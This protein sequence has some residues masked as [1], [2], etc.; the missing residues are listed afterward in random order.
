MSTPVFKQLPTWQETARQL[1]DHRDATIAEVD[2]TILQL[3]TKETLLN[4]TNVPK[5]V[6]SNREIELTES[7]PEYL[8]KALAARQLSATELT[9]AFLRR[10]GLAAQLVRCTFCLW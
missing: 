6:L 10:A 3:N 2:P 4:V 7:T 8:L 9:N 1:T 5:E